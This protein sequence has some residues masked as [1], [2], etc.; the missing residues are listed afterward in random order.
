MNT[1]EHKQDTKLYSHLLLACVLCWSRLVRCLQNCIQGSWR[2]ERSS[3]HPA[4]NYRVP[5]DR[6]SRPVDRNC[7]QVAC[8][9]RDVAVLVGAM[10]N[11]LSRNSRSKT[12]HSWTAAPSIRPLHVLLHVGLKFQP[13]NITY[14]RDVTHYLN[15]LKIPLDHRVLY[16]VKYAR[17]FSDF[18]VPQA[19]AKQHQSTKCWTEQNSLNKKQLE[20]ADIAPVPPPGEL[21]KTY[22]FLITAHSLHCDVNHK[23]GSIYKHN[24]TVVRAGPTTRTENLLKIGHVVFEIYANGQTDNQ[25]D[26]HAHTLIIILWTVWIAVTSY[27]LYCTE[28]AECLST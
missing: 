16:C 27:K 4:A 12:C 19:Q 23:T 6:W 20:T 22:S 1:D 21:D 10:V 26:R 5:R 24:C 11:R 18:K 15:K 9:L 8:L 14:R 13:T 25:A 28:A 17:H 7:H 3:S 2:Y